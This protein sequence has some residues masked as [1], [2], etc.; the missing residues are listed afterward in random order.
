GPGVPSPEAPA[1]R[2]ATPADPLRGGHARLA[3]GLDLLDPDRSLSRRD[4]QSVIGLLYCSRRTAA[5][6]DSGAEQLD[7]TAVELGPRSRPGVERADQP[8]DPLRRVGPADARRAARQLGGV[9][10]ARLFLGV[11][12][13]AVGFR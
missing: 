12:L 10:R 5:R 8:R 4:L 3:R 11:P 9:R 7:L 13:E 1:R 6:H 2:G